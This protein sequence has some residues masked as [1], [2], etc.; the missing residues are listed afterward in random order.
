MQKFFSQILIFFAL[1]GQLAQTTGLFCEHWHQNTNRSHTHLFHE[2]HQHNLHQHYHPN[3][4]QSGQNSTQ[5]ENEHNEHNCCVCCAVSFDVDVL[6]VALP[7]ITDVD[8]GI[9]VFSVWSTELSIK[10]SGATTPNILSSSALPIY[11]I[12]QTFLV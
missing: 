4:S 6:K 5:I 9:V 11:L 3:T 1:A 10:L 8:L 7:T 12:N 2:H